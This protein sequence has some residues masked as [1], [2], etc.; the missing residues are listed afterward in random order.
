[1]KNVHN[2]LLYI[3]FFSEIIQIQYWPMKDLQLQNFIFALFPLKT[4]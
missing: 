2:K 1:M 4:F 3:V